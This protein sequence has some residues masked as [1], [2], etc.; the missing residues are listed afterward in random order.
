MATNAKIFLV[1]KDQANLIPMQEKVYLKEA[2][3][4]ELLAL[5]PDLLPGDQINPE[6]PRRWLLVSREMGVPGREEETGRWSLDH[7]FLDQDGIPTF[8]ECKRAADAR[9][10]REVV[11]QMLDYAAN[12]V[13]YWNIQ[14]LRQEATETAANEDSDLDDLVTEL[15]DDEDEMAVEAFW[16]S[17]EKHLEQGKVRL[18]F[19]ADGIPRELRRLV[20]FLNDKM[21]DIE[22]LAVEVKRFQ[23]EEHTVLVPRVVGLTE[24]ARSKKSS[25]TGGKKKHTNRVEFLQACPSSSVAFFEWMLNMSQE[26]GHMIYWGGKGFSVRA[27]QIDPK[28]ELSSF[29]YGWPTGKFNFYFAQ[30][31]LTQTQALELRQQLLDYGIFQES[32]EKTLATPP[33]TSETEAILRQAYQFILD[34][35]DHIRQA[36]QIFESAT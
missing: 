26:R 24:A 31:P 8:V 32:G 18:I 21:N 25:A 35:V 3:L 13:E 19:V 29:A 6:N 10:R 33:V 15:I 23:S 4:Q 2:K 16:V 5:Y 34:E 28:R 36:N 1:A 17:V 30:L 9:I 22:V 12:G 27:R 20:E 7:L 11:A 14:R